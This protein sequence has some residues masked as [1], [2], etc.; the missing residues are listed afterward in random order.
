MKLKVFL[1]LIIGI[2]IGYFINQEIVNKYF[3]SSDNEKN[4]RFT[5]FL[6]NGNDRDF[7]ENNKKYHDLFDDLIALSVKRSIQIDSNKIR[8]ILFHDADSIEGLI[9]RYEWEMVQVAG[10]FDEKG[11]FV[12]PNDY[13]NLRDNHYIEIIMLINKYVETNVLYLNSLNINYKPTKIDGRNMK[14]NEYAL[15]S[16][17]SAIDFLDMEKYETEMNNLLQKNTLLQ[18]SILM[19]QQRL[20]LVNIQ[21]NLFHALT[22]KMMDEIK[23]K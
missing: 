3:I 5:Q 13:V 10:K 8:K 21:S 22:A 7:Y 11:F 9:H 20:R 2:M 6:I 1:I 15:L 4:F 17:L 16:Q 23:N 18:A 12:K 14:N 19:Q